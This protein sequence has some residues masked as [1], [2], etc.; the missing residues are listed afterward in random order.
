MIIIETVGVG[1]LETTVRGM[2]DFFLLLMMAGAGDELQGIKKGIME[3]ADGI[4]ITKADGENQSRATQAQADF[5][6]ALHLFQLPESGWSPKVIT[7]SAF[8]HKG[9]E[10]TWEMIEQYHRFTNQNGFFLKNRQHQNLSWMEESFH[11]LQNRRLANDANFQKKK[12][13]LE[14][15]ITENKIT[16]REAANQLL[17]FNLNKK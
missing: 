16:A 5:Q 13:E 4:A 2:V 7:T 10:K 3:M 8:E 9:I 12:K 11:L 15:K 14:N 17:S 1:Q 6:H